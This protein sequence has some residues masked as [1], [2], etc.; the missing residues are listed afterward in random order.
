MQ[1]LILDVQQTSRKFDSDSLAQVEN[2]IARGLRRQTVCPMALAIETSKPMDSYDARTWPACYTEWWF[3][4]GAPSLERDR[5]MLFE[6]CAQRLWDLEEMEYNL[7]TDE[8]RYVASSQSRFL[9]PEIIA[10]LADIVRR[11]KL[12]RGTKMAIG[13]KGFDADLRVLA[14]S[15]YED[16]LEAMRIAN[17]NESI[18]SAANRSDMSPKIRTAL[19]T[20][21]LSTS[22][23]PGTEGRKKKLR[24]DGHANNLLWGPPGF[25]TTPNLSTLTIHW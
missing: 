6:Q 22:A 16:F 8:V 5:S 14:S 11:M 20:L 2:C 4:D 12:N 23:V 10:V 9:K 24:H 1:S 21:L 19:R 15:S 18:V 17:P 3:G 7:P 13:R 25:F